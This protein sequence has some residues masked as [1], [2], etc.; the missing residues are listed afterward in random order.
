VLKPAGAVRD[1]DIALRLAKDAGIA[2][3]TALLTELTKQRE[4]LAKT[5]RA[6]LKAWAKQ[7]SSD[8]WRRRLA[9]RTP[10]DDSK[11]K[12][13]AAATSAEN[14]AAV[15]PKLA[16]RFFRAGRK[17]ALPETA[18]EKL[19]RFRLKVKRFRYM[20]ELFRPCYG[21][22][23][24]EHSGTLKELQDH[25]GKMTDCA[26][27]LEMLAKPAL[28]HLDGTEQLK[29]YLAEQIQRERAA[30]FE[31]WERTFSSSE[32]EQRWTDYFERFAGRG[33]KPNHSSSA[34]VTAIPASAPLPSGWPSVARKA[35]C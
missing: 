32:A 26:F 3:G 16:D 20:L 9:V 19:H 15:L 7:N 2:N 28:K 21:P 25:L 5:F 27:T 12:W 33:S 31:Y 24:D 14:A 34:A 29:S 17:V 13:N 6:D 1:R 4:Q 18:D 11:S 8:K 23:L 22:T 35:S 30:F 10:D